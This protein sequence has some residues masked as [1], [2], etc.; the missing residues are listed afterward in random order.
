MREYPINF[1]KMQ[2]LGNDFLVI[3]GISQKVSLTEDQIRSWSNRH[4]GIGF[5][6]LLLIEKPRSNQANFFYRIFNADGREVAQCGNG[7]RCVAKFV[8]D[9]GLWTSATCCFET[10]TRFIE[11]ECLANHEIKVNIG[12]PCFDPA[13]IP[14][15][16]PERQTQY[17][18]KEIGPTF[19]ALSVG[20]PHAVISVE[21]INA[22]PL[23]TLGPRLEKNPAFP[24][25]CNVGF[26]Q[27][28][29]QKSIAL[30][31]WERG[32]GETEAC[33]SG[34]CAAAAV[35]IAQQG[36]TSPITVKLRGGELTVEWAGEGTALFL[37]GP[38]TTVF[39]GKI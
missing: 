31:V 17:A 6:Q 1:T 34:A 21:D 37:T 12:I 8:R 38:A 19:A 24:E 15:I 18:L 32:V 26:M 36:C 28:I 7:A 10:H 16:F 20:N 25:H 27:R 35:A 13:D 29:D 2:A 3:D 39:T 4:L 23:L 33:G 22:A 5:D 9:A 11:T 14:L 30:R